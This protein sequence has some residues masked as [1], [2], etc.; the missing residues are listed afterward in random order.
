VAA[1]GLAWSL[2]CDPGD[3]SHSDDQQRSAMVARVEID[4]A[5]THAD[6][7]ERPRRTARL[8]AADGEE[9]LGEVLE[10]LTSSD[11]RTIAVLDQNRVLRVHTQPARGVVA[12]VEPGVRV[13]DTGRIVFA[14]RT[15]PNALP[16][17]LELELV[18]WD[19]EADA[20]PVFSGE[21]RLDRVVALTPDCAFAII[22]IRESGMP[23]VLAVDLRDR[24]VRSTAL[25][26]RD[27]PRT[28]GQR[29]PGF[30]PVPDLDTPVSWLDARTMQWAVFGES[31]TLTI[32]EDAR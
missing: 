14:R 6:R 18:V 16:P 2:G 32:P 1:A 7:D 17:E 10:V 19:P 8:V 21:E 12:H 13:C 25:A 23:V 22:V 5:P 20:V 24:P 4:V 29:P 31:V 11:G 30:V 15:D 28:P 26:N 27:L 9:L 3:A